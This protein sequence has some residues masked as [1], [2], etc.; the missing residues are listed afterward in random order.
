MTP[1]FIREFPDP[2]RTAPLLP[3]LAVPVLNNSKPLLP[4]FPELEVVMRTL[5]LDDIALAPEINL[6]SPPLSPADDPA[7]SNKSPPTP[8]SPAPTRMDKEPARPDDAT[9]DV[10]VTEPLFPEL[11]VPVSNTKS[12]LTPSKPAFAVDKNIDPLDDEDP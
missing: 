1:L 2:R 3:E 11:V 8:L 4:V 6:T 5:P 10:T 12:P 7:D 9:P